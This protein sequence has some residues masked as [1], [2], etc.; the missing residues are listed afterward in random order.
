M[1]PGFHLGIALRS[2][3]FTLF[4]LRNHTEFTSA[5]NKD[6]LEGGLGD[7]SVCMRRLFTEKG[8][9]NV[10]KEDC[11]SCGSRGFSGDVGGTNASRLER[12][13]RNL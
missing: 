13:R 2:G 1:I 10:L 12:G 8:E 3:A 4:S 9:G 11:R 7:S 5:D 6:D